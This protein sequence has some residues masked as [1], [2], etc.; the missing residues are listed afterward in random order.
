[1]NH[2]ETGMVNQKVMPADDVID[3]RVE[4]LRLYSISGRVSLTGVPVERLTVRTIALNGAESRPQVGRP[5]ANGA[6]RQEGLEPGKYH[7]SVTVPKKEERDGR[8]IVINRRVQSQVLVIKDRDVILNFAP[9]GDAR[10]T[11]VA[12]YKGQPVSDVAISVHTISDDP[13]NF[14]SIEGKKTNKEGRFELRGLPSARITIS[15]RKMERLGPGGKRWS[16]V[17]RI[18][19]TNKKELSY[20][21]ELE[22]EERPTLSLGD[23]APEFEAKQLDG[24]T[25]RLSD[26]RGKKAVLIDFWATWCPPCVDEIPTIKRIAETYRDQGL[27]VVGVS[28]DREEKALRDFI[29]RE[30]LGYVQVFEKE[31]TRA[32]TKSY[33]VWSIPSVFLVDKNGVIKALKLRGERTEKAIKALL[34][35]GPIAKN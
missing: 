29:K 22:M 30:K 10:I 35:N 5:D 18:D 14:V 20:I 17:D 9:L 32:I 26:Y 19:L 8:T 4:R 31:K 28:L 33:G 23:I 2:P 16:K 25:F 3:I 34:A 27:E 21:A 24:S 1:M 6:Y 7:I 13:E 12:T 11:G 15:F